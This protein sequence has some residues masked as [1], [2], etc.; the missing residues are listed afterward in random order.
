MTASSEGEQE[1]QAPAQEHHADA[2]ACASARQ[3]PPPRRK[4]CPPCMRPL[5]SIKHRLTGASRSAAADRWGVTIAIDGVA[6]AA[7]GAREQVEAWARG[8]ALCGMG[9]AEGGDALGGTRV[10]NRGLCCQS[11]NSSNS[12]NSANDPGAVALAPRT[13]L[14][15][16]SSPPVCSNPV[17]VQTRV[18]ALDGPARHRH[19][20]PPTPWSFLAAAEGAPAT[21]SPSPLSADEALS[22]AAG[23]WPPSP[24]AS[25]AVAPEASADRGGLV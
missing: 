18:H 22:M 9:V 13:L 1:H 20:H 15:D 21:A 19:P 4:A 14:F 7:G 5:R 17:A 10:S 8:E 2:R 25:G 3:R 6:H 12:S 11:S 24:P 16:A 23:M